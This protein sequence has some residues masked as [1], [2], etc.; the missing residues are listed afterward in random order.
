LSLA[1]HLDFYLCAFLVPAI[2]HISHRN[3]LSQ[4]RAWDSR[5]HGTYE[6]WIVSCRQPKLVR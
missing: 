6:E 3:I 1:T 4:G 5:R 2:L